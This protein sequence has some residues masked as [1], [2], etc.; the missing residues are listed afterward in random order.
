MNPFKFFHRPVS[1]RTAPAIV[2]EAVSATAIAALAIAIV[3]VLKMKRE[4][5]VTLAALKML[6]TV[7]EPKPTTITH[8]HFEG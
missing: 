1:T 5:A 2:I 8:C 3:D 6:N 7:A 4:K